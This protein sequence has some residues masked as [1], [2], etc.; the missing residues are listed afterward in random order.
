MRVPAAFIELIPSYK[1]ALNGALKQ[2]MKSRLL[3]LVGLVSVLPLFVGCSHVA[4]RMVNLTPE[5]LPANPSG[6]YTLSVLLDG[7]DDSQ[8]SESANL[9]IGGEVFPMM[10]LESKTGVF[11]FDYAMPAGMNRAKYYFELLDPDG[12]VVSKST[13]YDLRL[14]NRYV[15]EMESNR[16]QTGRPIAVLGRGFRSTDIIHFGDQPLQTRFISENQL[17]FDVPSLEGGVDY[18][19]AL[20]T[21]AGTI[22]VGTFRIDYSELR[23]VP[24]RIILLEG[25]MT[26][27]VFTI[28][29]DAPD[30]G[31]PLQMYA[32]ETSLLEFEPVTIEEGNRSVNVQF[33][34]GAPGEGTLVVSAAAHNRLEIPV[35]VESR[36][37]E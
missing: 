29:Q 35:R 8:T 16:A 37:V 17:E 20:S 19:V 34:G 3:M 24:S 32:S 31:V 5:L 18:N 26:T 7:V 33:M 12:E 27:M 10:P 23:S 13:V 22:S 21:D 25:Q 6:I 36:M 28:D 9:V 15:V 14:T 4:P 2:I 1:T 30:G 11:N